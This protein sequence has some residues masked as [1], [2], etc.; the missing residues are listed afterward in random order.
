M[1]SIL[2]LRHAKSDWNNPSLSDFN[3]PLNKRGLKDAPRMGQVLKTTSIMPDLIVSSPSMRT[4][5]TVELAMPESIYTGDILWIDSLYGGGFYDI[6]NALHSV[7][8]TLSRPM[9]V[10]HNPG[11][12]ETVSL[13][14]SP[15]GQSPTTHAHIRIP[16]AGLA[17][18]DA[19]VETWRDLKPGSCVLRWFLI[20]KLVKAMVT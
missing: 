16:T 18:L 3:R 19:H 8:D 2:I 17:Y 13:L 9:I 4:K 15:Q 1:K 14:L 12:E 20:P 10:G 11:V 5:A 7:P 6:L